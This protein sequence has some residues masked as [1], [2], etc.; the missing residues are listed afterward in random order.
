MKNV[1]LTAELV[2]AKLR[3]LHGN[4]AAVARHCG[5]TRG[6]VWQFCQRRPTLRAVL[7]E[8][9]E[10]MK[11]SA[12][13]VLYNSVLK[14]EAWAVC[15]YLKCQ[16]KDRGYVEKTEL[17]VTERARQR[18]VEEVVDGADDHDPGAAA[19]RANGVPPK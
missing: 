6:T 10:A 5:C 17:D 13:S 19:P 4:M 7:A 1:G 14:G 18:V 11:D 16:A 3:E 15:F 8:C 2:E 12:E 9:R